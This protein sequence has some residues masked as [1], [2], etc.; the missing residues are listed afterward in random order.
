MCAV[1]ARGDRGIGHLMLTTWLLAALGGWPA[2]I[3]AQE[4]LQRIAPDIV[5]DLAYPLR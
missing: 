3:F 1:G 4:P 5:L 2:V